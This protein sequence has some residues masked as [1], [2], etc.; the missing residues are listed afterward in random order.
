MKQ[1]FLSLLLLPMVASAADL[2]SVLRDVATARMSMTTSLNGQAAEA[3]YE[4]G[5][6]HV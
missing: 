6:A 5:R 4:I 2:Q 1:L 3:I